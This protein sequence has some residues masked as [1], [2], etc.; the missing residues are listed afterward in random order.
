MQDRISPSPKKAPVTFRWIALIVFSAI[1]AHFVA[2]YDR[3]LPHRWQTY[4]SSDG[5]FC[6]QLPAKPTIQPTKIPLEGGGTTTANEISVA[7]TDH[8]AYM[9][10]YI[11]NPNVDQKSPDEVLDAARDGGLRKIQGTPLMQK[12]ITVRGYP[13]L[14]VQA[15]ARGNSLADLRF[16]L[17]GHRLFMIV[18]VATVDGDREPKTIQRIWD[19]FRIIQK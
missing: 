3:Y 19:S 15:R 17:V 7:P 4:V 18:A 13:A 2:H 12:K 9:I 11:D 6:I 14:D 10:T 5:S 1:V 8:N 16:V